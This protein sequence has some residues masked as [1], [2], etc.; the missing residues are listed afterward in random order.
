MGTSCWAEV[1]ERTCENGQR[2]SRKPR[3]FIWLKNI[4]SGEQVG[5]SLP[6]D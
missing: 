6:N 3:S 4:E 2:V 1:A 5:R